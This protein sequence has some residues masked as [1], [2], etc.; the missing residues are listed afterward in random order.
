MVRNGIL[1][2]VVSHNHVGIKLVAHIACHNLS[3]LSIPHMVIL[4]F[5]K[6][7]FLLLSKVIVFL[8]IEFDQI[9]IE[10][11]QFNKLKDLKDSSL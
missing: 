7:E 5:Q 9:P 1:K 8:R 10:S 11:F 3:I 2:R 4:T 6:A